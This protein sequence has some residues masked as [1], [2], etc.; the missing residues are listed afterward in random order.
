MTDRERKDYY[1]TR[2]KKILC[3]KL[4]RIPRYGIQHLEEEL[5]IIIWNNPKNWTDTFMKE[6]VIPLLKAHGIEIGDAG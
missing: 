6:E 4:F 1:L 2:I 5:K 3:S